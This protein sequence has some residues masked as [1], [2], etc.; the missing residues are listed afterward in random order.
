M[1]KR[2]I[3]T[4]AL[5][6]A[7]VAPHA[8]GDSWA[9]ARTREVFSESR[10]YFVRVIP[11]E[12]LGDTFGFAGAKKGRYAS[13]EF[14]RRAPDRSYRLVAEASLLN[15]V[16]PVEVLVADNG[17]LVALDNWHNVG[18][19]AVV[20]I[21][22]AGGKRVR[23]YELRELFAA[24]EIK[25]FAHS[26]SSIHWRNGPAYVR[27]DQKTAL[28]TVKEGADFLFGVESGEFKYCEYHEKTSRCRN[29]AEPRQWRP[30]ASLPLER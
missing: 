26:V 24:E 11:G 3:V 4:T 23:A 30:N 22:D 18:Y 20:A 2:L 12:S 7:L 21:Y 8:R 9:A 1:I 28:V 27:Q 5:G 10:E 17:H 13:A 29:A 14:Y 25:R 16:A 19:G 6:V 15:P